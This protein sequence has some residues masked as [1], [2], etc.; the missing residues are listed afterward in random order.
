MVIIQERSPAWVAGK[1]SAGNVGG[2]TSGLGGRIAAYAGAAALAAALPL[3]FVDAVATRMA[4]GAALRSVAARHGVRLTRDARAILAAPWRARRRT[5]TAL[6]VL[7]NLVP[8]VTMAKRVEDAV[9]TL[10][11]AALFDQYL[12]RR[13]TDAANPV[14]AEEARHVRA[15]MDAAAVEGFTSAL[16][17]APAGLWSTLTAAFRAAK[18]PDEEGRNPLERVV[19]ALLDGVSEATG[20]VGEHVSARFES[21]VAGDTGTA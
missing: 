3:P 4:R 16:R 21:A 13:A 17:S 6:R 5:G 19:D 12:S 10:A 20:A 8:S 15:A 7:A 2:N 1:A 18:G 11:T 9:A 14:T